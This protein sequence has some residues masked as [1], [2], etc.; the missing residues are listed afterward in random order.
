MTGDALLG[1][2]LDDS[3]IEAFYEPFRPHRYRVLRLIELSPGSAP[4]RAPRAP[5]AGPLH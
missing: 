2:H 4:R 5:R 1:R 3:E